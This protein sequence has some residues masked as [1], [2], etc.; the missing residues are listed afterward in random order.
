V[1]RLRVKGL[2]S[3][4]EDGSTKDKLKIDEKMEN[5]QVINW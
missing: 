4:Q 3:P 2:V 1:T 5:K